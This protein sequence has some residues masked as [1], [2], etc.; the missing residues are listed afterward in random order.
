MMPLDESFLL[1]RLLKRAGRRIS[2]GDGHGDDD[3]DWTQVF[4]QRGVWGLVA[5]DLLLLK[6]QIPFFVLRALFKLLKD[7]RA[8]DREDVLVQGGLQLFASLRPGGGGPAASGRSRSSSSAMIT[9]RDVHH[10][11][12]LFYMSIDISRPQQ[13]HQHQEQELW[14]P[15]ATELEDAG[16]TFRAKRSTATS[17]LDVSFHGGVLE[18]PPLELYDDSEALF[19]NLIAFEQTYPHM[20]AHVTAYAVLMDCLIKTPEDMRLLHREGV[21]VSH[22]NGDRDVA[23]GFFSR[24]CAQAR[25]SSGESYLSFVMGDVVRYQS[26]RWPRW[27]AALVR[28]YLSNPWVVTSLA[29]AIFLLIMTVLQT[30]FTV[31]AYFK[32]PN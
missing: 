24:A 27:R 23:T 1:H 18:I 4:G 10:L 30:Y 19:R 3:D 17:F 26:A 14:V 21:L 20:P 9:C 16:V 8:A 13:E 6:N 22:M 11:L 31:Y 5:R 15:C 29:A 28:N 32:P 25:I 12:H 2:T 7:D